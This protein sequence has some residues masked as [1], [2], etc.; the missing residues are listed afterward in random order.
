MYSTVSVIRKKNEVN[1]IDNFLVGYWENDIWNVDD[2]EMK[3]FYIKPRST[4]TKTLDFS[5][6]PLPIRKELKYYF[7]Y[8]LTE[9]TFNHSN[10][11][12]V[13]FIIK[14]FK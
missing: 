13:L 4:K 2:D 1:F 10:C 14:A 3:H 11:Y 7:A 6:L 8:R 12:T 9:D 5:Y